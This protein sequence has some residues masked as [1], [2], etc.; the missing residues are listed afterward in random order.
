MRGNCFSVA[1]NKNPVIFIMQVCKR[2]FLKAFALTL[3]LF[4][5]SFALAQQPSLDYAFHF[6]D[7]GSVQC[8]DMAVDNY[9]N[10]YSVGRFLYSADFDPGTDEYIVSATGTS[11]D[12]YI[13]KFDPSGTLVWMRHFAGPTWNRANG[14]VVDDDGSVYVIGIF[15]GEMDIDPV[16]GSD[17]KTSAGGYDVF[18]CKL[19]SDGRTEW[20]R[21]IGGTE[22]IHS[23][24]GLHIDDSGNLLVS[25]RFAGVADFDYPAGNGVMTSK[26]S[27]D[28]FLLKLD[29][30]G[31]II[32]VQTL[33]GPGNEFAYYAIQGQES[34][35]YWTGIFSDSIEVAT[36]SGIVKLRSNG[37]TDVFLAML[38]A[39]G[40][41]LW[42][43]SIGGP[44]NDYSAAL[45]LDYMGNLWMTGS[46][47]DTIDADPGIGAYELGAVHKA[48]VMILKL[49][50][51]G[52]LLW[53]GQIGGTE[54]EWIQSLSFDAAGKVY[55]TGNFSGTT[56]FD[57]GSGVVE[58]ASEGNS[59][60]FILGL[61][62]GG[63]FRWVHVMQSLYTVAGERVIVDKKGDLYATGHFDG[64]IDADPGESQFILS[65]PIGNGG[66]NVYILKWN[67]ST[68]SVTD[69][70]GQ[71]PIVFPNPTSGHIT[72]SAE[73]P[74]SV[75]VFDLWGRVVY[76]DNSGS[77]TLNLDFIPDGI[78]YLRIKTSDSMSTHAIRIAR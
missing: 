51:E 32:W 23:T 11:S 65:N 45:G 53:A 60:I 36:S 63:T 4:Y 40:E 31:N 78:Y 33:G 9:G 47:Q 39:D 2:M 52:D 18:V 43:K 72:I 44:K 28:A 25:G 61:D 70:D 54:N 57:P 42:I 58:Y 49:S 10:T 14:I 20:F 73:N 34:N 30:D 68:S 46:F 17:I 13:T 12:V 7:G 59:D 62:N 74:M 55:L 69:T 27:G 38:D 24:R 29:Q 41:L 35:I 56:D 75:E 16:S 71:L 8:W 21:Q 5:L 77:G 3:M 22:D 66:N 48:D 6:G 67:L 37:G 26:G 76:N 1:G 50:G 19:A 15:T 64:D